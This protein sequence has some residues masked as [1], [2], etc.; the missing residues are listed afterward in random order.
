MRHVLE[1]DGAKPFAALR[2]AHIV[3]GL[4]RR[5]GT[6][7]AARNF[8]DTM[9]GLFRWAVERDH[10]KVDP[11]ADVKTPKR[12]KGD[13]FVAWTESDVEAYCLKWPIGTRQRVWL[14]VL[15]YTGLRRGDAVR[16]GKQHVREGVATIRTEKSGET[17][18]VT[19]PV[20]EVLQRTLNAGPIGD[21]AWICGAR[22]EPFAKEAFGNE[23]SAAAR[24][25]GVKKSAH[26]VRKIAATTAANN[27]A[28]VNELEAI[29]GWIGGGM[30]SLY[31]RKADRV[32]L[33]KKAIGKLDGERTAPPAPN[34]KVRG[35]A[36]NSE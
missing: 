29:F 10:V 8:L 32:K 16:I 28:T 33:A 15:L 19:I 18:E 6:P 12:K 27:G 23:F 3:A 25:A 35:L 36:Q 21:L 30:A 13:G 24:A 26:G 34:E 2:R 9:K 7:A 5:A 4:D 1:R 22:G 14:D 31:T 11:T 17:I 20:L